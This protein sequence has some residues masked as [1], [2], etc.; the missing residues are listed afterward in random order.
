M[1]K[2]WRRQALAAARRRRREPRAGGLPA[3]AGRAAACG[4]R[5][6]YWFGTRELASSAIERW[7]NGRHALP[8]AAQTAASTAGGLVTERGADLAT[9]RDRSLVVFDFEKFQRYS[10]GQGLTD[11][12]IFSIEED[13]DGNRW[14]GTYGDGALRISRTGLQRMEKPTLGRRIC[15]CVRPSKCPNC[16]PD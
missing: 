16:D 10:S 9:A 7:N 6:G 3:G 13:L 11:K 12:C 2:E 1:R 4:G 5:T 8:A 14:L 15:F